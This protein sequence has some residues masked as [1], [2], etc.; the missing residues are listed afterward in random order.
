VAVLEVEQ[1][2]RCCL[3]QAAVGLSS[4]SS[5][6]GSRS[7]VCRDYRGLGRSRGS[8][9]FNSSSWGRSS[10]SRSSSFLSRCGLFLYGSLHL[11]SSGGHHAVS[12]LL[13]GV[14]GS[15]GG[16]VVASG[17]VVHRGTVVYRGSMVDRGRLVWSRGR[18]VWSWGGFVW[19]WGWC[20]YNWGGF[21]WS[22]GGFVWGGGRCIYNWGRFV[23]GWGRF[24]WSR[25]SNNFHHRSRDYLDHRFVWSRGRLVSWGWSCLVRLDLSIDCLALVLHISN[26][27]L[28]P[29]GVG[30]YL[31][32]AIREVDSVLSSGVVVCTVLLMV[33]DS[34][35]VLG[36][37]HSILVIV[38]W[39]KVWVGLLWCRV[40]G[41]GPHS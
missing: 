33:E 27:A 7:L 17:L 34:A 1:Q 37:I 3:V 29:C 39:R 26:I 23:R 22:W 40:R 41:R 20:I 13:R 12:I 2:L 8:L 19:G 18:F 35:R 24:V 14:L 9:L 21:V 32:T 4:S 36:V 31:D 5:F 16:G 15:K 6:C 30:H 11:R 25:G 38:Y 28:G 10:L